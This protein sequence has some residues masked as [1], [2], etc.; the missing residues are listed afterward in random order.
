LN[1]I[2]KKRVQ[3]GGMIPVPKGTVTQIDLL[4]K[5][6]KGQ[7]YNLLYIESKMQ[8]VIIRLARHLV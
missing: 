7:R 2:S 6:A 8:Y 3:K 4:A 5:N 1:D